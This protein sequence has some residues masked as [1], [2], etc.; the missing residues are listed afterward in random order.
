MQ[1][2]DAELRFHKLL[3]EALALE[4]EAREVFILALEQ[5]EPDLAGELRLCLDDDEDDLME[6]FLEMP[7]VDPEEISTAISARTSRKDVSVLPPR[8]GP[9]PEDWQVKLKGPQ[10]VGP[11]IPME[12]VGSGGMGKVY[13]ARHRDD[14]ADAGPSVALKVLRGSLPDADAQRRFLDGVA[15]LRTLAHP[16]LAA[17]LE[18]GMADGDHP[19]FGMEWVHGPTIIRHCRQERTSLEQRLDLALQVCD[20]LLYAHGQG[21][22][23]LGLKPSNILVATVDGIP[24]PKITDIGIAGAL[25]HTLTE[26]AVL[27]RGGLDMALYISPEAVDSSRGPV[28]ALSDV[29]ALGVLLFELLVGVPPVET[30]GASLIEVVQTILQGKPTRAGERWRALDEAQQQLLAD[31][32]RASPLAMEA[33]LQGEIQDLLCSA[34]AKE[35]QDRL[36]DLAALRHSLARLEDSNWHSA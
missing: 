22:T 14:A 35:R 20:G 17:I 9:A 32:R 1:D 24:C 2:L 29:Y 31:E 7:A 16:H 28:D 23:H 21:V 33:F 3:E 30:Q 25:D 10:R 18:A 12:P 26:S 6:D 13:A 36:P 15:R 8:R 34:M 19:F 5:D 11:Y 4:S 27:T